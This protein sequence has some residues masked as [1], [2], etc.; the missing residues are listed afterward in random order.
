MA[1]HDIMMFRVVPRHSSCWLVRPAFFLFVWRGQLGCQCPLP[2]IQKYPQSSACEAE[3]CYLIFRDACYHDIRH[4]ISFHHVPQCSTIFQYIQWIS[5]A[6]HDIMISHGVPWY[7]SIF[8]D[9]QCIPVYLVSFQGRQTVAWAQT[10]AC[11]D[12]G[13]SPKQCLSGPGSCRDFQ[14]RTISWHTA[15]QHISQYSIILQYVHEL[16][17]HN[18]SWGSV[19]DVPA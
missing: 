9:F 11:G 16:T 4:S 15:F 8:C 6:D 18:C 17:H 10:P 19:D 13:I 7:S 12:T 14:R 2:A 3:G 1:D 5:K